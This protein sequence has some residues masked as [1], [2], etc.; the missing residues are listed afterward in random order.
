MIQHSKQLQIPPA[1]R[2]DKQI[3][4]GELIQKADVALEEHLDVVAVVG[5]LIVSQMLTLYLTPIVYTYMAQIFRTSRI[6]E[7]VRSGRLQPAGKSA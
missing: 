2:D 1:G 4:L 3:W 6:R 5:G 7:T